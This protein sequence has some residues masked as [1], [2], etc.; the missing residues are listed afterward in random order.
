MSTFIKSTNNCCEASNRVAYH[1]GVAGKPYSD[2]ELVKRCLIE[3]VKCIHPGKEADYSS[4]A[5]S[6]N[7]IQRSGATRIS[8]RWGLIHFNDMVS[9]LQLVVVFW[10]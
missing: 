4:L 6:R 1:L 7:T 5:L 8:V 3:V 2:G 10:Y 9:S